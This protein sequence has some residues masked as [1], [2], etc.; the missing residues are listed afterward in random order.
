MQCKKIIRKLKSETIFY[1]IIITCYDKLDAEN[2]YSSLEIFTLL[3][4]NIKMTVNE[5]MKS[6]HQWYHM[7]YVQFFKSNIYF[8]TKN[9][10]SAQRSVVLYY[11]YGFRKMYRLMKILE[12]YI[13]VVLTRY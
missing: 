10:I 13:L 4:I 1:H 5:L 2:K 7:T 3:Q 9:N 8:W 12:K 6:S 11:E